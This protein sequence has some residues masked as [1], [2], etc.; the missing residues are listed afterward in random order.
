MNGAVLGNRRSSS[1]AGLP[2][3]KVH[4][5]IVSFSVGAVYF[6]N[7]GTFDLVS[8]LPLDPLPA[9]VRAKADAAPPGQLAIVFAIVLAL[10][11]C[12]SIS[13]D[14][15]SVG[16]QVAV[17]KGG[18]ACTIAQ[19]ARSTLFGGDDYAR[20]WNGEEARRDANV[21]VSKVNRPPVAP[22]GAPAVGFIGSL[23]VNFPYDEPSLT[24]DVQEAQSISKT[25][26]DPNEKVAIKFERATLDF[27]LK[28]LLSGALGVD[29]VAPEDLGGAV[30]FRTE[31]PL[32]KSQVLQVVRDI[33]GRRGLVMKNLNGVYQIDR[34]DVVS[35]IEAASKLGRDNEPNT[36]IVHVSKGSAGEVAAIVR[37]LVPEDVSLVPTGESIVV[38]AS[39]PTDLNNVSELINS[40]G[41]NG[42]GDDKVAVIELRQAS[43]ARIATQLNDF[44]RAR[45]G[46]IGPDSVT[47]IPLEAQNAILVGAKD[48][49]IMAGLRQLTQQLDRNSVDEQAVRIIPLTHISAE[50]TAQR[51]TAIM[52]GGGQGATPTTGSSAA[53]TSAARSANDFSG[54]SSSA[55]ANSPF[56][57]LSSTQPS[58]GSGLS[59][60]AGSSATTSSESFSENPAGSFNGRPGGS[61]NPSSRQVASLNNAGVSAAAASVRFEPDVRNNALMVFSNFATFKKLQDIIKAID[62]PQAQVVI[63]ATIAEVDI[64]DDL[65]FGV[66][67]FLQGKGFSFRNSPSNS[68]TDPGN[69]GSFANIGFSMGNVKANV[70]LTA[71]QAVT[72]VKVISSPYLTVLDK[73]TARLVIGDQIPFAQSTQTSNNS[74]NTTITENIQTKDTGVVLEVTPKINSDNSVTITI[75]QQ[76]S[77]PSDSVNTGNKTPVISTRQVKSD[78]L[79][80]SGRTFVLGGIMQ[81]RI[82][83]TE[84]G[85]PGLRAVP[86]VG[87]LF[88]TQQN[89]SSRVELLVMITPRVVRQS[90]ELEKI[91]RLLRDQLHVR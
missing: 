2:R 37:Q 40:L 74:G 65:Q 87:D 64:T 25:G 29:Y 82:D 69:N 77:K 18:A 45:V 16:R 47:I 59:S 90:N 52:T 55:P 73:K 1:T 67:T 78:I 79:V 46:A 53:Q 4:S 30:T 56:G 11:A 70:V 50:E 13:A 15:C 76:I 57:S 24:P 6:L 81:E 38:K 71:L 84:T 89:T 41:K 17:D 85:V 63:E 28:Q 21:D 72:H 9:A 23:R 66:Q 39:S 58:P 3:A 5:E 68:Q 83:K 19:N 80:Q 86:L 36:R 48:P 34:A 26:F 60:P 27:F 12:S 51:L 33:L 61:P 22:G 91:T 88:K 10:N 43:P 42:V 14:N 44:Y 75:D 20:L 62:V 32:P 8:R 54:A 7:R 49:R 31:N 35:A